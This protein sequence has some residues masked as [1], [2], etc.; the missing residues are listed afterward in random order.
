VRYRQPKHA[1][2]LENGKPRRYEYGETDHCCEN[3]NLLDEWLGE[4]QQRVDQLARSGSDPGERAMDEEQAAR[5]DAEGTKL[6][7]KHYKCNIQQCPG[8]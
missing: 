7:D 3:F 4:R 2:V 5:L 6:R 8:R 1:T